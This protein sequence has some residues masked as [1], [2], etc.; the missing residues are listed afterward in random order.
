MRGTGIDT[1]QLQVIAHLRDVELAREPAVKCTYLLA[2][3]HK[4]YLQQNVHKRHRYLRTIRC[5]NNAPRLVNRGGVRHTGSLCTEYSSLYIAMFVTSNSTDGW[6]PCRPQ[7]LTF[8]HQLCVGNFSRLF[9]VC[10]LKNNL[11]FNECYTKNSKGFKLERRKVHEIIAFMLMW[12]SRFPNHNPRH[13]KWGFLND[14]V[15][16][17]TSDWWTE[18][19]NAPDAADMRDM[20]VGRVIM[21]LNECWLQRCLS[22]HLE[23]LL[24]RAW[25]AAWCSSNQ[26]TVVRLFCHFCHMVNH[27]PL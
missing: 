1:P 27:K 15:L 3:L 20:Q 21:H 6:W 7:Q 23:H 11:S 17:K 8:S 19:V 14:S 9:I 25:K 10:F 13:F 24:L 18:T 22:A 5:Q 12:H 26:S 4:A 2:V 16:C